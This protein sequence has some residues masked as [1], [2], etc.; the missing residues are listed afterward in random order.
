MWY[1]NPEKAYVAEDLARRASATTLGNYS[2]PPFSNL[3]TRSIKLT[4]TI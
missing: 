2:I 3:W 1:T 4:S